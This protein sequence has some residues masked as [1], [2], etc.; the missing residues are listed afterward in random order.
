MYSRDYRYGVVG[1]AI[2]HCYVLALVVSQIEL[3]RYRVYGN[4]VRLNSRS[5]SAGGVGCTVYYCH[6]V[7]ER[8]RDVDLVGRRIYRDRVGKSSYLHRRGYRVCCPIDDRYRAAPGVSH[9]N[10]VSH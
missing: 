8:F 10:F 7:A 6:G 9:V 3:V 4:R 1:R 2:Q 5:E